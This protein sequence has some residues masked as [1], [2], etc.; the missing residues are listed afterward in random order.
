MQPPPAP[1]RIAGPRI[2]CAGK[3]YDFE[4]EDKIPL[5]TIVWSATNGTVNGRDSTAWHHI[6]ATFQEGGKLHAKRVSLLAPYAESKTM[7]LDLEMTPTTTTVTEVL[8][9]GEA[10]NLRPC[11]NSRQTFTANYPAGDYWEWTIRPQEA[12]Q[13]VSENAHQNTV[14]ILWNMTGPLEQPVAIFCAVS[15][16][17]TKLHQPGRNLMQLPYRQLTVLPAAALRVSHEPH[18]Y[19]FGDEVIFTAT[20]GARKYFWQFG[21]GE[22]AETSEAAVSH[23]YKGNG[24]AALTPFVVLASTE[25]DNDKHGGCRPQGTARATLSI[26]AAKNSKPETEKQKSF[27][28]RHFYYF[29]CDTNGYILHLTDATEPQPNRELTTTWQVNKGEKIAGQPDAD[30]PL[31]PGVYSIEQH[32]TATYKSATPAGEATQL[33]S[34][35]TFTVIVP[36]RPKVS[37]SMSH[38]EVC[39]DVAVSFRPT[40][41]P[42][43]GREARVSY[44]WDFGDLTQSGLRQ[45]E[46]AY[47]APHLMQYFPK[48]TFIDEYGCAIEAAAQ[49]LKLWHNYLAGGIAT[50]QAAACGSS[51]IEIDYYAN[52]GSRPATFYTWGSCQQPGFLLQSD[53]AKTFMAT[54]SG[55]YFCKVSDEHEC[56]AVSQP[57]RTVNFW[58]VPEVE[59]RGNLRCAVGDSVHLDG[60]VREEDVTYGWYVDQKLVGTGAQLDILLPAGRY[61][62]KLLVERRHAREY[63]REVV[64]AGS[65]VVALEVYR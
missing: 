1:A 50:Q 11:A 7:T 13:V 58:P 52:A 10:E 38:K 41:E 2:V 60:D 33:E 59:I 57:N 29:N 18:G 35:H 17:N 27:E 15:T 32:T 19:Q 22:K 30:L 28:A 25:N 31:K 16:C 9:P 20:A 36:Q 34:M 48:L 49:P 3:P 4:I 64:C 5:T 45:P 43:P 42:Q 54:H 39:E 44:L 23:I 65:K 61:E 40:V 37:F 26:G 14:D 8:Q 56:R 47:K 53:T 21:D 24:R 12:G 55:T 63:E 62:V 51:E 46:K 6:V